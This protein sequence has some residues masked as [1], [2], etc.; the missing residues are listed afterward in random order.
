MLKNKK[1]KTWVEL[2]DKKTGSLIRI[3]YNPYLKSN[4]EVIKFWILPEY[5]KDVRAVR[6]Y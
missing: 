2:K 4:K 1:E 6:T 3:V 5:V